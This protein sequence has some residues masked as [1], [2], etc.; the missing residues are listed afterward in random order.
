MR[1]TRK[2]SE[3]P[4]SYIPERENCWIGPLTINWKMNV[5]IK[6]IIEYLPAKWTS[7]VS[8]VPLPYVGLVEHVLAVEDGVAVLIQADRARFLL[9]HIELLF[10]W[11]YLVLLVPLLSAF[12]AAVHTKKITTPT[13]PT[14]ATESATGTIMRLVGRGNVMKVGGVDGKCRID[15]V[16][17]HASSTRP[18]DGI[19]YS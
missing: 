3:E 19:F 16:D 17:G 1:C 13:T 2:Y 18:A 12:A 15:R 4:K 6:Q 7:L 9:H 11:F 10:W 8:Y 5:C 14:Q